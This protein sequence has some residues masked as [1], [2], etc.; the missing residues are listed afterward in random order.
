VIALGSVAVMAGAA[1][2][3]YLARRN[4]SAW[5]VWFSLIASAPIAQIILLAQ[6]GWRVV[7]L[8]LGLAAQELGQIIYAITNVVLRQ[9]LCPEHMLGRVNATM[10]FLIM[11]LFPLGALVGGVVGEFVGL[12]SALALAGGIITLS[13]V[14]LYRALRHIRDVEDLPAWHAGTPDQAQTS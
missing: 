14:P 4:G 1:L 12:R 8:V 5:I 10:R 2:T 7:L 11:R 6:P 13:T 3:P 9:R